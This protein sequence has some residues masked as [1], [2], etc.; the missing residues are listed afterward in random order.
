MKKST[1]LIFALLIIGTL[2]S[3][4]VMAD[5]FEDLRKTFRD[6]DLNEA[7]EN[8]YIYIDGLIYILIFIT[9]AR[10]SLGNQNLFGEENGKKL[11]LILGI[12]LGISA[13]VFEARSDFN[14]A[15]LGPYVVGLA[16]FI[17]GYIMY[18]FIHGIGLSPVKSTAMGIVFS[19]GILVTVGSEIIEEIKKGKSQGVAEAL[20][21]VIDVTTIIFFLAVCVL[22]WAL[23]AKASFIAKG[24]NFLSGGGSRHNPDPNDPYDATTE[25]QSVSRNNDTPN[26]N[27]DT[28]NYNNDIQELTEEL[29]KLSKE[30][31][32]NQRGKKNRK[33]VQENRR[34]T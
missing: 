4:A 31:Q 22:I 9:V 11:G 7:Y 5:R 15:S 16:I 32:K 17:L 6:F 21:L 30:I 19:Y 1:F 28:P 25:L 14:L 10:A 13:A 18:K 27:N 34:N 29:E 8:Y 12:A 3:Q 33:S 23:F 2:L 20:N 26:Y 24:V